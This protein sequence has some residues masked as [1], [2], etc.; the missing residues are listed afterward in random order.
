MPPSIQQSNA[1]HYKSKDTITEVKE[2][3]GP[4]LLPAQ[5]GWEEVADDAL[6]WA[7]QRTPRSS[8]PRDATSASRTSA[9]RRR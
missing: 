1:K 7:R 3:E 2:Y 8:S 6:D 5:D 4:H 9:G